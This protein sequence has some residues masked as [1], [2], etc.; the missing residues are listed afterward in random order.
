MFTGI[1]RERGL[2]E[3]LKKRGEL[4]ELLVHAPGL[5]RSVEPSESVCVSGVCLSVVKVRSGTLLF[6]VIPETQGLTSLG[7]LKS[8]DTVNLEPSL[9]LSDRLG[10]HIL[11]GHVDGL[12]RVIQAHEI[13]GERVLKI[14]VAPE[15]GRYLTP[16]GPVALDGISMTVGSA[17]TR[18][19]FT[20][21]VIP[22]TLRRTTLNEKE[23]G[24]LINIEIDYL[25][26]LIWQFAG[27]RKATLPRR[28]RRSSRRLVRTRKSR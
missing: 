12:G 26:K 1:V 4:L 8:G 22:E 18:N 21:H 23:T 6:E 17:P 19:V 15:V 25:A 7:G 14:R 10:G 27:E 28:A 16:K 3:S 9:S 11:L 24:D 2:V 13:K 20:I 5:A